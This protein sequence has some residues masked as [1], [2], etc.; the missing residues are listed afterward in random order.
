MKPSS[1]TAN[2]KIVLFYLVLFDT[3]KTIKMRKIN[4][5]SNS[6][7]YLTPGR[8][9][10]AVYLTPPLSPPLIFSPL[11]PFSLSPL[12]LSPLPPLPSCLSPPLF[13]SLWVNGEREKAGDRGEKMGEWG[14]R[15]DARERGEGEKDMGVE[16]G[17][18]ERGGEGG[19]EIQR[20]HP[21]PTSG[22][23]N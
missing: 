22:T 20:V 5:Y 14:E 19:G 15:G 16:G 21:L 4:W 8:G 13:F 12:F 9:N 10:K 7:V 11:A 3:S 17:K 18:G 1:A 23:E 2:K 6:V